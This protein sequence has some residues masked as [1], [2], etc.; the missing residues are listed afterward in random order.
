[1]SSHSSPHPRNFGVIKSGAREWQLRR[2][3]CITQPKV[4]SD[5]CFVPKGQLEIS[6]WSARNERSHRIA[7]P[8]CDAA[9]A[10]AKEPVGKR[11]VLAPPPGR[12]P[13]HALNRWFPL[14]RRSTTG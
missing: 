5:I 13:H 3:R 7:A 4:A 14:L 2:R 12:I 11:G 8:V 6:R 9:P 1:M 10:G